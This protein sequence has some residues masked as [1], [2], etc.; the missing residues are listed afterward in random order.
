MTLNMCVVLF[1][2]HA[3]GHRRRSN[4]EFRLEKLKREKH[5]QSKIRHVQWKDVQHPGESTTPEFIALLLNAPYCQMWTLELHS[6]TF[7]VKLLTFSFNAQ[8]CVMNGNE[9]GL[10]FS[11]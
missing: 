9:C 6:A 3:G 5:L 2:G 8:N 7:L 10:F 1:S 4:T 11:G